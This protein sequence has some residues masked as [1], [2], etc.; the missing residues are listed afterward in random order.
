VS[1]GGF[2]IHSIAMVLVLDNHE[3]LLWYYSAISSGDG[4][5][6]AVVVHCCGYGAAQ[7]FSSGDGN[8]QLRAVVVIMLNH[9]PLVV[10]L[11]RQE[12]Q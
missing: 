3:Q 1:T 5:T 6:V 4:H 11:V 12:Q 9:V 7:L 2:T 10:V 8:T